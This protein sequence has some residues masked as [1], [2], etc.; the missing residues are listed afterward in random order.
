[1]NCRLSCWPLINEPKQKRI[2]FNV[3]IAELTFSG[4][5][6]EDVIGKKIGVVFPAM[7][8]ASYP[9]LFKQVVLA[10]NSCNFGVVPYGDK[11]IKMANFKMRFVVSLYDILQSH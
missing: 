7:L 4:V 11:R 1:M 3:F 8:T 2:F 10:K 5:P 6:C 9:T